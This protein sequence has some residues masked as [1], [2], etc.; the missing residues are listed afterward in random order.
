[1]K[2]LKYLALALSIGAITTFVGCKDDE[3]E[4]PVADEIISGQDDPDLVEGALEGK[5]TGS[6]T[7]AAGKT[8]V[9]S[10]A[11]IVE[12]GA[13]LTIEAGTTIKAGANGADVF[14][15]IKQGA[16]I[17]AV[18]TAAKP[19]KITSNAAT[20]ALGDWGG[21]LLMGKAPITGGGTATTEV[22][23][24][25]FGGSAANDNS[26][27]MAYMILE[28]TGAIIN[29]DKEFNGLTLYGVGSGT[30]ISNIFFNYSND[31]AVEFFGGTVNPSN[32]LIVNTKDDM[33]DW[34]QGYTGT[35]TNIYGIR[36]AGFDA[37]SGD[38]RGLEGDGNFDGLTPTATGQSNPTITNL[39]IVNKSTFV[40]PKIDVVNDVVKVRRG[41]S[42]T[43][44][45]A[46]FI[47]GTGAQNPGDLVDFVDTKGDAAGTASISISVTG[48][49][50][51]EI[52]LKVKPGANSGTITI[53][54]TDNTGC[55]S[56]VFAW[57]GYT[58]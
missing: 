31:D 35:S 4:K 8:W 44:T 24:F 18:G 23:D 16:K 46:L 13:T 38:P 17:N 57:T 11:L 47:S 39:T 26:G 32:M 55:P 33:F 1:M 29:S 53:P 41:S 10:G 15:A 25:T 40:D 22:V 2:M 30:S 49:N 28:Y 21:L 52:K 42:A 43:I 51:D 3:V 45:N 50:A 58:F 27:S 12:E 20:P 36:E 48:T 14:I 6:I 54:A 34:T 5:V 56:S 37:V 7:L 19:I 9:L